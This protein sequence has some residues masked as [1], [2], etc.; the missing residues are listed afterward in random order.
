MN[1]FYMF[2][3]FSNDIAATVM[4]WNKYGWYFIHSSTSLRSFSKKES[5]RFQETL[6]VTVLKRTV[7]FR[8]NSR[9][10]KSILKFLFYHR[11]AP[12]SNEYS[13]SYTVVVQ[14]AQ[15]CKTWS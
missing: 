7:I 10:H 8:I 9:R 15:K 2:F 4:L 14:Y 3:C 5:V 6:S 13:W 1:D 12:R 11:N